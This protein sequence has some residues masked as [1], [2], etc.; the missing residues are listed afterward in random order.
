M[1]TAGFEE[2]PVEVLRA[3]PFG[4]DAKVQAALLFRQVLV[5]R[6]SL[7][8]LDREHRVSAVDNFANQPAAL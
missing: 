6:V 7:A 1:Q 5:L 4:I 3:L 2:V 8:V